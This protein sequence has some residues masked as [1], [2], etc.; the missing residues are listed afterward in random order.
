[1]NKKEALKIFGCS[2][3]S[4]IGIIL[5]V[6]FVLPSVRSC[7]SVIYP[8]QAADIFDLNEMKTDI[9]S[10]LINN[11]KYLL[12]YIGGY[13]I[14]LSYIFILWKKRDNYPNI[15]DMFALISFFALG[16]LTC[17][18]LNEFVTDSGFFFDFTKDFS[19][20]LTG[21][22]ILVFLMLPLYALVVLRKM[23]DLKKIAAYQ[24]AFSIIYLF[25]MSMDVI[26]SD[27]LYGLKIAATCMALLAILADII[28]RNA[29]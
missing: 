21:C 3:S 1:M 8:Y 10:Y 13:L 15:R 23:S 20:F 4:F 19:G 5:L 9:Y 24:A 26:S 7:S 17:I 6:C 16:M 29:S 14:A 25:V 18:V 28:Y 11:W 22:L 12:P 2:A 27:A